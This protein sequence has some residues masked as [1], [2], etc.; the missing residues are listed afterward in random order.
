M[1][2]LFFDGE[3]DGLYGEI[4]AIGAVVIDEDGKEIDCFAGRADKPPNNLKDEWSRVNIYPLL[5]TP[6]GI[7][8]MSTYPGE[9]ELLQDFWV[10]WL[11]H[12]ETAYAV[13]DV[14]YPVEAG[15]LEKCVRKDVESRAFM[16]PFPLLDLSTLIFSKGINPLADNSH[17]M[18]KKGFTKHNPLDDARYAAM[19]W[20]KNT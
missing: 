14:A 1:N 5:Y 9:D 18:Q 13:A 11:K 6:P 4:L 3:A 8:G 19:I 2:L 7:S 15:I 10:F 20:R 17:D 12:R 16:A